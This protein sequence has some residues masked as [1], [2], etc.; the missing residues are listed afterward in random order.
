MNPLTTSTQTTPTILK[1]A[2][3]SPLRSLFDYLAPEKP[4]QAALIKPGTRV[5]VNFGRRKLTGVVVEISNTSFLSLDK[6]KPILSTIDE[7]PSLSKHIIDLCLWSERYYHHPIGEIVTYALPKRLR[8][9]KPLHH[10]NLHHWKVTEKGSLIDANSLGRASKQITALQT[11]QEHPLGLS[12]KALQSLSITASTLKSLQF[13]KLVNVSQE[14]ALSPIT[15]A[16]STVL[17][18]TPLNLNEEQRLALHSIKK[19]LGAS[20]FGTTNATDKES[21][22]QCLV[23]NGVTGSGKT[24]VYL[25]AI[26]HCLNQG[27]Q[28]LVLIPEIGLSPQTLQRFQHRF[29][30]E[31]VSIHSGLSDLER[32]TNWY[33]AKTGAASIIIGTR[34]AVFS[35]IPKLGIIIIDEEHD[36]SYKQQEGFRFSARDIAIVRA[37]QLSI[38]VV[39]GSATPCFESLHNCEQNRYQRIDLLKRAGGN[40]QARIQFVDTRDQSLQSGL[41]Q[42]TLQHIRKHLD[43]EQQVLIFINRRGYTPALICDNC[44][45]LA[46]CPYCD[47]RFTYHK[48]KNALVCHHCD[49]RQALMSTCEKCGSGEMHMLGQGTERVE[50]ML[51]LH[52]KKN[53]II[54]IDRDSTQQKNA[55]E[56]KIKKIHE[57]GPC[58]LV[59]TQ[60]LAKGHHFPRISMVAI[61]DADGGFFSS[62]FRALEKM[63]QLIIQIAGRAGR[64]IKESEVLIQTDYPDHPMLQTLSQEGYLHFAEHALK[65]REQSQFPPFGFLALFRSESA[66]LQPA[67]DFLEQAKQ[68]LIQAQ[69]C[70]PKNQVNI[71]GP[72]PA[73]MEKRAGRFRAQLLLQSESRS[74]M[75][76]LLQ[77]YSQLIKKTPPRA[78]KVRWSIDV[79]PIELF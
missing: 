46:S 54:R 72:A 7:Q 42:K 74:E 28:A 2:L 12:Q 32:Y 62:D 65:E 27:K 15:T 47:A 20:K 17:K 25:Q 45:W 67:L 59:G 30:K 51:Q 71:L 41:A 63:S 39:L 16:S 19:H 26:E 18:N 8:D 77:Q 10:K 1:V 53:H 31:V 13:K 4:D 24:E 37:N 68:S 35:D 33:K 44:N 11:L 69:N 64:E 23:L 14:E 66:T 78:N 50:E 76:S 70:L 5:L 21:K 6:L 57:G 29:S 58:I 34:S 73:P 40:N 43:K 61:L 55:F 9:N 75:Q 48:S 38:P 60:M 3:P 52:F 36:P 49:Y 79:D 22:Y 56:E